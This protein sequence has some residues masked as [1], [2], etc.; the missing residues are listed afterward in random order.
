[1]GPRWPRPGD[2]T[3]PFRAQHSRGQRPNGASCLFYT[4]RWPLPSAEPSCRKPAGLLA[5]GRLATRACKARTLHANRL[6]SGAAT[7]LSEAA[8]GDTQN[9]RRPCHLSFAWPAIRSRE[10]AQLGRPMAGAAGPSAVQWPARRAAEGA[11]TWRAARSGTSRPPRRCR[12]PKGD[13][14]PIHRPS[15]PTP[16]W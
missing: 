5:S 6:A 14:G 7:V 9:M 15:T 12:L 13:S 8:L 2:Y 16:E 1:M 11:G 3:T 10:R 4:T